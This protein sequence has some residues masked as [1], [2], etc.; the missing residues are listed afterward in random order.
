MA[1]VN[2]VNNLRDFKFGFVINCYGLGL[3]LN[4]FGDQ[5]WKFWF[6]HGYVENWVYGTETVQKLQGKG[7]GSRLCKN[8]ILFKEFIGELLGRSCHMKELRLDKCF[9]LNI[10]I[11]SQGLSGISQSL[12]LMLGF[13]YVLLGLLVEF[14]EVG[15]KV[16]CTCRCK[17]TLGMN[18]DVWEVTLI[19]KEGC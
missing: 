17:V 1:V 15:D 5:V 3:G 2:P 10:E 9:G 11:Q 4:S 18:C 8:L 13:S 14:I 16:V 19:G 6:Q 7:V 12:I